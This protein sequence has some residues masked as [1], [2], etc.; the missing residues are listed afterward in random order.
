MGDAKGGRGRSGEERRRDT[1]QRT[2]SLARL[3]D[4]IG[5]GSQ[6]SSCLLDIIERG[7]AISC[8]VHESE[9]AV[10]AENEGRLY[11]ID[12]HSESQNAPLHTTARHFLR[13]FPGNL[14]V[15]PGVSE[16]SRR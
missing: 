5:R 14:D 6:K 13:F 16:I 8:Y 11:G 3:M 10:G 12:V 9:T 2:N 4:R 15:Q 7:Y 1:D